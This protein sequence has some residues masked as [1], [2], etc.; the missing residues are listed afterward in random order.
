MNLKSKRA[1]L[2]DTCGFCDKEAKTVEHALLLCGVV[3][4]SIG[5]PFVFSNEE[6]FGRWLEYMA[7][8]L[9]KE[10]F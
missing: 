2:E 10:S 9:S 7:L 1:I 5:N 3:W 4:K 6:G 8:H